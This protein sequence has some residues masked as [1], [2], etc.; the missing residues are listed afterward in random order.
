MHMVKRALGAA[1]PSDFALARAANERNDPVTQPRCSLHA[2]FDVL[3]R[4]GG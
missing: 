4:I 2:A 3:M 1:H